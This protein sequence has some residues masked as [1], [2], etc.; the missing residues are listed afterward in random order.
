M[1]D[2]VLKS[3]FLI[4]MI[5]FIDYLIM[6][7]VGCTS[8]LFG[9]TNNFYSCTYCIIGKILLVISAVVYV[10]LIIPDVKSIFKKVA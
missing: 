5:L 3:A 2:I 6:A 9:F 1:K 7:I 8:C 4:P 10:L